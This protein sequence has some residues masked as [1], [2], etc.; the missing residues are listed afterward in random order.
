M[1][2]NTHS[3]RKYKIL[4]AEDN[5]LNRELLIKFLEKRNFEVITAKNGNE[6]FD[7]Y[8][9]NKPDLIIMD[10]EMPL[11]NGYEATARIR[12]SEKKTRSCVPIMALTGHYL[13][14]ENKEINECGMN[15]YLQKPIDFDLLV[16]KIMSLLK[17]EN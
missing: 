10:I 14:G 17:R 5:L 1:N 9:E 16:N 2:T 4:I 12:E 11:V 6:A 15:D 3:I 8:L 13:N 7:S